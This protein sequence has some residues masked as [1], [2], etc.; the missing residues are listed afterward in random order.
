MPQIDHSD[1][2]ESRQ[3]APEFSQKAYETAKAGER[4]LGD[5]LSCGQSSLNITVAH[6]K[7]MV[8]LI[9]SL[10][11]KKNYRVETLYLA[12][13]VADRYL[14]NLAERGEPAPGLVLLAVTSLL[15]AAKAS[16]PLKPSYALTVGLLPDVLQPK[17][18]KTAF[19][20]LEFDILTQLQF[21]ISHVSPIFF[22]ERYQRLFGLD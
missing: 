4:A 7:E 8:R 5:Y 14:I 2:N 11:S 1:L 9:E 22:L 18:S 15:I 20:N 17:V 3:F 13:N 6:R 16:Q 10:H 12:V 19:V 21:N